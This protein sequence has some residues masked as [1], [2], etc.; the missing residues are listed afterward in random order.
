[1]LLL[2]VFDPGGEKPYEFGFT[3]APAGTRYEQV[4]ELITPQYAALGWTPV[5]VYDACL[6]EGHVALLDRIVSAG[7]KEEICRPLTK[8]FQGA[9]AEWLNQ[10]S[11][12]LALLY[13][14]RRRIEI[15]ESVFKQVLEMHSGLEALVRDFDDCV[16][17]MLRYVIDV[18][19]CYAMK[20][21]SRSA[22]TS[23]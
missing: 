5:G 21:N 7:R 15:V 2:L 23:N 6:T 14:Y 19:C 3:L 1:V 9:M 4:L 22:Y 16:L 13:P 11:S 17:D 12:P 18:G 8:G 10:T 20:Q